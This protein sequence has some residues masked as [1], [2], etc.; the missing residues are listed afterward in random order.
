M[1]ETPRWAG[2]S[3]PGRFPAEGVEVHGAGLELA[4]LGGGILKFG[5]LSGSTLSQG[6]DPT[7]LASERYSLKAFSACGIADAQT[8]RRFE[9]GQ[10]LVRGRHGDEPLLAGKLG[11]E[12]QADLAVGQGRQ[13]QLAGRLVEAL[14]AAAS[15]P[16]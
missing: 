14:D 6:G 7:S 5:T 11:V 8:D 12:H 10:V 1:S 4:G 9:H 13:Q 2:A 16:S 15:P 3:C